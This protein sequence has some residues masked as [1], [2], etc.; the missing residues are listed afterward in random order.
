MS[1]FNLTQKKSVAK[2]V[3]I[4]LFTGLLTSVSVPVASSHGALDTN[5]IAASEGTSGASLFVATKLA[6]TAVS[7]S[8]VSSSSGHAD[9]RSVGLFL[10]D[11]SSG[12]AQTATVVAG[13]V[14]SLYAQAATTVAVSATPGTNAGAGT[15]ATATAYGSNSGVTSTFSTGATAVAFTGITSATPVALLYTAPTTAGTVTLQLYRRNI[16]AAATPSHTNPLLGT[17]GAVITVHVVLATKLST[18][19]LGAGSSTNLT[20]ASGSVN[21]SLLVATASNTGGV[22]AAATATNIYN[23]DSTD[24]A[25]SV[26]LLYKDSTMGTAQT[27]TVLASGVLSLYAPITTT[28]AFSASAGTFGTSIAQNTATITYGDPSNKAL[29]ELT[30]ANYSAA[31]AAGA[32][33]VAALWTAPSTAGTYTVSLYKHNGSTAVPTLANPA[34]GTLAASI[35]VTVVAASAGGSYSAVNSACVTKIDTTT[36]TLTSADSTSSSVAAGA[37]WYIGFLLN[38]AYGADLPLGSLIATATNGA[39]VNLGADG[40]ALAAG[41]GTTAVATDKGESDIVRV[42]AKTTGVPQTTT[43]TISHNGVTVCTKTLTFRGYAASMVVS[44]VATV[45]L[46]GAET[47]DVWLGEG[48]TGGLGSFATSQTTARKGHYYMQLL[49]SAGNVVIPATTDTFAIDSATITTTVTNAGSTY[50]AATNPFATSTTSTSAASK[51]VGTF[52]CG[53]VAGSSSIKVVHTSAATGT[54]VTSPA[55]TAR[56]ADD[57]YSFSASWDKAT[58]TAG[59]VATLTLTFKDSKGNAANSLDAPG[60]HTI[61]APLL[62]NVSTTGSA[63]KLTDANGV[64]KYTYTVGVT[65]GSYVAIIDFS[66][67]DQKETASYKIVSASQDIEFSEVLKSVI[68]LI[69]S[70]NKQIQALQKLILKRK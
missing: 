2:V 53:P 18:T 29:V 56:C 27:A 55:F 47:N 70:I 33:A 31:L 65:A 17:Q 57:P 24:A 66:G 11:T 61:T 20:A 62:T 16:T 46:G 5:N 13:G 59:D 30:S 28:V 50:A 48:Q 14:L 58:Y 21:S 51:T 8:G 34:L 37:Q 4:G 69:A 64:I 25:R 52:T 7:H 9:A 35:T 19:H 67:L 22:S 60:A 54:K 41:T 39:T 44:N 38:D 32:T 49:D 63:T 68:A 10:K 1:R 40:G 15:V 23:E 45:D 3:L 6:T 12:T 42:D 26:G 36:S 43:V